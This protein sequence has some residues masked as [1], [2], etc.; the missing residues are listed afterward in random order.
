MYSTT[1]QDVHMNLSFILPL[2]NAPQAVPTPWRDQLAQYPRPP[3]EVLF[4]RMLL[5]SGK[6]AGSDKKKRTPGQ[7][8]D[9]IVSAIAA[10]QECLALKD[11]VYEYSLFH[12]LFNYSKTENRA[13]T[14]ALFKSE[15]FWAA[16][17]QVMRRA[18]EERSMTGMTC[19]LGA[20][21]IFTMVL[22]VVAGDER[23]FNDALIY[24]WISCGLF[25][26]LEESM[27]FLAGVGRAPSAS[28][29]HY[30]SY[31]VFDNNPLL[32]R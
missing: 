5:G 18:L 12:A 22:P 25:D 6:V 17:I 10:H 9:A 19:H 27:D 3:I 7:A 29:K 32:Q 16:N 24:N 14:R 26:V 21:V 11:I 13:F 2:I 30:G 4:P 28:L 31:S 20:L 23:E 1:A 8:A 15:K